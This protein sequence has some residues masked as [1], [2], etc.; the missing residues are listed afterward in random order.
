[1]A[2]GTTCATRAARPHRTLAC[3]IVAVPL[4][5]RNGCRESETDARKSSGSPIMA[6]SF[7]RANEMPIQSGRKIGTVADWSYEAIW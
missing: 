7:R 5:R 6:T 3:L 1:M 2:V 4:L